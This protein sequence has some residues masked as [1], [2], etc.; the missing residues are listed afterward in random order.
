MAEDWLADVRKYAPSADEAAVAGIVRYC[1]IALRNR[2]SSLVS[3]T[4]D[5][6]RGRVKEKFL[7]KKLAL[8]DGDDTL[9]QAMEKVRQTMIADHTKNRV[10]VYYLLADHFGKLAMFAAPAKSAGK[11][12]A[13]PAAAVAA[14]PAAVTPA[15]V[16]ALTAK[17]IAP[18]VAAAAVPAAP[19]PTSAPAA[20]APA[21]AAASGSASAGALAASSAAPEP[22]VSKPRAADPVIEPAGGWPSWLTWVVVALVVLL[23]IWWIRR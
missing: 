19:P 18:T 20:S 16:A 11:K 10:T 3:F 7:R 6:E 12:T 21:P 2:D 9:D 14:A 15:P 5:D 22:V 8:T 17:T 13:S 23:L 1:G 4:S